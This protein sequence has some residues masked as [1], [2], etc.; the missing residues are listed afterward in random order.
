MI[1]IEAYLADIGRFNRKLRTSSK[2]HSLLETAKLAYAMIYLFLLTFLI[3]PLTFYGYLISIIAICVDYLF[4]SKEKQYQ[5]YHNKQMLESIFQRPYVLVQHPTQYPSPVILGYP[6]DI[7]LD[8]R[9][10]MAHMNRMA[11]DTQAMNRIIQNNGYYIMIFATFLLCIYF[12]YM[13]INIRNHQL[14]N[15]ICHNNETLKDLELYLLNHLRLFQLLIDGDV[16]SNPGPIDNNRETPKGKA[17]RP[18]KKLA[19]GVSL[20]S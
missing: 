18:K 14:R 17:G 15:F 6:S 2:K 20:R 12:K 11:I 9:S 7:V 3:I 5:Q 16:E 1:S 4:I 10:S 8:G 19:S 13:S